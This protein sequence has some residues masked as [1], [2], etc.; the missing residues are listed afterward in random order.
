M[1]HPTSELYPQH[2][3]KTIYY[4]Q[5]NSLRLVAE[6]SAEIK[7]EVRS[8]HDMQSTSGKKNL[9]IKNPKSGNTFHL[10][11]KYFPRPK[12]GRIEKGREGGREI[13]D[14]SYKLET[15]LS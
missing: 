13:F 8:Q 6:Y 15:Y 7:V 9:S 3:R 4:L 10:N 14:T 5:R 1:H 11:V 2:R 12:I